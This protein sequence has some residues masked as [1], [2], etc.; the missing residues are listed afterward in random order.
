LG[1]P[2]I[3]GHVEGGYIE[4]GIARSQEDFGIIFARKACS[5][6]HQEMT[7]INAA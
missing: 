4:L 2:E 3:I 7:E 6:P 1:Y 5:Q